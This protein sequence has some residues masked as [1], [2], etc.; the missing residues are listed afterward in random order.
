MDNELTVEFENKF[1][2]FKNDVGLKSSFKK[3][4]GGFLL[5]DSILEEGF[6]GEDVSR[7]LSRRIVDV[8]TYWA[9]NI[10]GLILPNPGSI[11]SI[12]Q[13]DMFDESERNEMSILLNKM[14][15]LTSRNSVLSLTRDKKEEAKFIDDSLKFWT[16]ELSPKMKVIYNKI[17]VSWEK[18]ANQKY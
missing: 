4:D 6:V 16:K 12:T 15:A 10:H 9:N 3:L 17:S 5:K 18:K 13:H 2:L 7:T 14:L 8:Y 11:I 1:K